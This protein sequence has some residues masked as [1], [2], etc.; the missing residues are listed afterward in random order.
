MGA[1]V[2]VS[3][4]GS[5]FLSEVVGTDTANL[6]AAS[7]TV[8]ESQV[9]PAEAA[10]PGETTSPPVLSK[11]TGPRV[12][13]VKF[14]MA[15]RTHNFDARDL[16]L[17]RGDTVLVEHEGTELVGRVFQE[18]KHVAQISNLG[19][20]LRKMTESDVAKLPAL[21]VKEQAA[22]K[23]ALEKLLSR[24]VPAKLVTCELSFNEDR[25]VFYFASEERIDLRP[26]IR[27][28]ATQ[29]QAR[30]D[31]RQI[32]ARDAAKFIGGIGSCG[33][34]LCCSTWLVD[35]RP[36]SIKMAKDQ[37]LALNPQ[38]VSGACGRLL[39]C[40]TYEQETYAEL[41]RGLPKI[42][43]RVYTPNGDGRVKDVDV[44]RRRVRVHLLEGYEEFE[45]SQVSPMFGSKGE[46]LQPG[47]FEH[48]GDEGEE[49]A[50]GEAKS[51]AADGATGEGRSAG[52]APDAG[53]SAAWASSDRRPQA[54]ARAPSSEP[55]RDGRD[56]GRD[57]PRDGGDRGRGGR[58]GRPQGD[59]PRGDRPPQGDRAQGDR[60]R[61]DRP[62][63]DDRGPRRDDR[64]PRG[65]RPQ[66]D[67]PAQNLPGEQ[68]VSDRPQN[69]Q[70]L[71]ER[72]Q[73]DRPRGDRPSG[74]RPRRD[75]RG[76]RRDDR[77]PRA[78]RPQG[79][80][81]QGDRPRRDDRGPRRDDR[82]PRGDRPP[83]APR[84][85][86]PPQGDVAPVV[87]RAPNSEGTSPQGGRPE[88]GTIVQGEGGDTGPRRRR[89]RR[90]GRGGGGQGGQSGGQGAPGDG[91]GGGDSGGGD[92]S[93]DGE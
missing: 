85:D 19:R 30:V 4:R 21:K 25:M 15:G 77:G 49:G 70:P 11:P 31:V 73:G 32:G 57:R 54:E 55:R 5:L 69:D 27:D 61:G 53:V 37:N 35:F 2:V 80:R 71:G 51:A 38:K 87:D 66:G 36:V 91:G 23:F 90:R 78:D 60:A 79:D 93:G 39:C 26:L 13:Q 56:G 3:R 47:T 44:L 46:L 82:G 33:R 64:G 41:R 72:P 52:E 6:S 62:R 89:R 12:V 48:E 20:V 16:S 18:P 75:D 42:G 81:P 74:D 45:A 24:R 76:P 67:R 92:G 68:P 58:D 43:K 28:L 59:R 29:F 40:L 17:V 10:L 1:L 83:Q 9:T 34:E 63:R 7:N 65:D 84:V 8:S 86:R 88:G 50:E 14:R 22:M